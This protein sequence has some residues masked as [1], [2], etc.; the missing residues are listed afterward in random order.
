VVVIFYGRL[1]K[2]RQSGQEILLP[3]TLPI[4][5]GSVDAV[6]T[7][8]PRRLV[9]HLRPQSAQ[10]CYLPRSE[11]AGGT[12]N[13]ARQEKNSGPK[14]RQEWS[15]LQLGRVATHTQEA[16]RSDTQKRQ[17]AALKG[18]ILRIIQTRRRRTIQPALRRS[19][20]SAI[21]SAL[22]VSLPYATQIRAGRCCPHPRHWQALAQFVDASSN[23]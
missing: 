21:A 17:R 13:T 18:G 16:L 22:K 4:L 3:R 20:V 1:Y 7:V 15:R 8:V 11:L 5:T 19:T 10:C 6:S 14:Q 23:A 12:W 2:S 9:W